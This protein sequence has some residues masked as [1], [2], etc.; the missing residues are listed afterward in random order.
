ML[1][2]NICLNYW[3]LKTLSLYKN[4][5]LYFPVL[6]QEEKGN[7]YSEHDYKNIRD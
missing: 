4:N 1:V 6:S 2:Q 7:S 5:S 3:I